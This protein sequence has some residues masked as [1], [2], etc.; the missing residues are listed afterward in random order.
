[1]QGSYKD[2][3]LPRPYYMKPTRKGSAY[4]RMPRNFFFS[5]TRKLSGYLLL[6]ILFSFCMYLVGQ[7]LKPAPPT[8]F[9]L[10][11]A[12]N[13]KAGLTRGDV[14]KLVDSDKG[15]QKENEKGDLASNKAQNSK[16][17]YGHA[18]PEAPK[19]GMVN[20]APV[21]GND[22]DLVVDGKTKKKIVDAVAPAKVSVKASREEDIAEKD[23]KMSLSPSSQT[24]ASEKNPSPRKASQPVA[25]KDDDF[26]MLKKTLNSPYDSENERKDE[27]K[28]SG[29]SKGKASADDEEIISGKSEYDEKAPASG[30]KVSV[31][32]EDEQTVPIKAKKTSKHSGSDENEIPL[33][34]KDVRKS[35]DEEQ[36]SRDDSTKKET[37]KSE[38]HEPIED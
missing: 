6:L 30:S 20:E 32:S 36:E 13:A 38:E 10:D 27:E 15:E 12:S 21:V 8:T 14:G 23:S 7:E 35:V 33:L 22:E 11:T 4:D 2:N 3:G 9:E 28:K 26:E 29:K 31:E 24:S 37:S 16:G 18:I 17:E 34:S 19:G 25:E 5:R 1:M